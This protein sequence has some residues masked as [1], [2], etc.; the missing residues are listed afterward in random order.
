MMAAMSTI[1]FQ[2]KR[3]LFRRLEPAD[4]APMLAI[5]GDVEAMRWV[6]DGRPITKE[7]CVK[8]L[9]VTERN[10]RTRGYGMFALVDRDSG[11]VVG[12]CGVVHPGGQQEAEIKYALARRHWGMGFATE[13]ATA[14]L[15]H[16]WAVLGLRR[17]VATTAPEN[18]ASH[19]VL[20]KAGMRR[21]ELRL[22]ED[23]SRTQVFVWQHQAGMD[24]L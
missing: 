7:Q 16:A 3:M 4:L 18:T 1:V 19:N 17:I 10:Y 12:F 8:W 5:Y 9:E 23:G 2:T 15:E 21:A 22:E 11:S 6:G 14:M 24:S 20:I 13:A